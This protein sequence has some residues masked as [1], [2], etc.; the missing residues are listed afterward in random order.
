MFEDETIDLTCPN[1]GH[2]NS[3]LVREFEQSSEAHIICQSCKV[4]V[5]IEAEEFRH[6]LNDV[7]KELEDIERAADRETKQKTRRGRKGDFQI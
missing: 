4:G 7:R 2:K 1:C 5:K 3:V 6:R